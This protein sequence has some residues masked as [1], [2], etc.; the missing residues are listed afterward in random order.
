MRD[1][2][3]TA[4]RGG[5]TVPPPNAPNLA[6]V[7][8]RNIDALQKRRVQEDRKTTTQEKIAE[9]ITKFTGSMAFVYIHVL[10]F[11]ALDPA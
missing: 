4:S 5:P 7:L 9:A 10:G 8:N 1:T 3:S 6:S 2:G 11:W